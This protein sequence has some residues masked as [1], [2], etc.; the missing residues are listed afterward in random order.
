MC[1]FRFALPE[2]K[3]KDPGEERCAQTPG[4]SG[5]LYLLGS[6]TKVIY[7]SI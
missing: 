5:G 7:E 6:K 2:G 4:F 1:G 3:R